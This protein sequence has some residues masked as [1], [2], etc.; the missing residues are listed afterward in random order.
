[1][2]FYNFCIIGFKQKVLIFLNAMVRH[3]EERTERKQH[4]R[5][6]KEKETL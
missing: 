3:L 4:K 6:S 5:K 2:S 1:M